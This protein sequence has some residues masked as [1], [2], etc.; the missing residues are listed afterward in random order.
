MAGISPAVLLVLALAL[1]ARAQDVAGPAADQAPPVAQ[2]KPP[3]APQASEMPWLLRWML[4]PVRRGMLVRL[5]I[6]DTDPNRGITGGVM[7][8]WVVQ[9]KD[10]PRIEHI[11]APS[12]TYNA[13][14]GVTP[15]YR[16]YYYPAID[17]ALQLRL[18]INRY[19]KEGMFQY[20]DR[21]FLQTNFDVYSRFQYNVDASQRFF[22]FG[23]DSPEAAESNYKE[24]F[25]MYRV[26]AGHPLWL[27]SDW[28]LHAG[29]HLQ[30]QKVLNGPLAGLP[31]TDDEFPNLAAQDHRQ[32]VHE[33][34][35]T[36]DYDTRD[37]PVTTTEGAYEAFFVE[38]AIKGFASA[39][40]YGRYGW[41][42][43]Y[44]KPWRWKVPTV[45]AAQGF[46]QQVTGDAPFWAQS[47]LGGKYSLRAYGEGRYVD[48]GVAAVNVEQRFQV[49]SARMAGVTTEFELAPF[50]GVGEVFGSPR[51]VARRY[52]RPVFG[53]AFRAVARPQVVGSVDIGVGREGVKAFM[54]INYSF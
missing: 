9:E 8:I 38:H 17:E 15:T 52:A 1:P 12:L 6:I 30:A 20:E 21:S 50:A 18:S 3:D 42:G 14:F 40:D 37:N 45:T 19:E 47:S 13:N 24:D 32:Q 2:P 27:G 36:L 34:R 46:F 44:F 5:P 33:L 4:Q 31:G 11:H 49:F 23:P 16:Y 28:R 10:G 41:D 43:R 35:A 25:L 53:G 26:T 54:D 29:S 48:R 7:P 39:Y 51:R 22:G